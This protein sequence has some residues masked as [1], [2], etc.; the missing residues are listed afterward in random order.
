MVLRFAW[1]FGLVSTRVYDSRLRE[2]RFGPG[3]VAAT[4][5]ALQRLE[6]VLVEERLAVLMFFVAVI[7]LAY[8]LLNAPGFR[9]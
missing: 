1:I 6:Q 3:A 7:I 9:A 5:G 8:T 2:K 4:D